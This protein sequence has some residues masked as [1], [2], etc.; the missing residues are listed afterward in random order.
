MVGVHSLKLTVRTGVLE[1][2][3]GAWRHEMGMGDG[4]QRACSPP[5]GGGRKG[6]GR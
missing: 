6:P 3:H 1:L 5:G 2:G 4:D